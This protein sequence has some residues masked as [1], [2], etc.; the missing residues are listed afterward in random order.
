MCGI[1]G[2][3]AS[4]PGTTLPDLE[5]RLLA[6]NEIQAH[7]GPDDRGIFM[8]P[9]RR[10]GLANCRLAIRDLSPAGHMPMSNADASLWITY[11]GELYDVEELRT[12]LLRLGYTFR[13]GSDTEVILNGYEAWGG[14]VVERLRGIFAFAVLDTRGASPLLFLARDRLGVK[15]LY[16]LATPERFAFASELGT[17]RA[18][19][20]LTRGV[21]PAGL[22]AYLLLGSVPPPMTIFRDILALP[23][24]NTLTVRLPGDGSQP[25]PVSYWAPRAHAETDDP[26][27]A[28]QRI[29]A[30]LQN[31]VQ[32]ELV[33][34]V[35]LGAFLSGGL[36]SSA[37]VGLMRA[38]TDGTIRTCSMTF[39]EAEYNEAP[40]AAAMARA[41]GAEHYERKV[42]A[43]DVATQMEGFLRAMGQPTLD[44]LN[45][46]FVSQTAREAGLTVALSGLGGD[47]LFGGYGNTFRGGKQLLLGLAL[48]N[49]VPRGT[50]LARRA[51]EALPR[52]NR[53]AKLSDA[54][55]RPPSPASAYL[56]RR[57]NFA[58]S[59]VRTLVSEDVWAEAMETFD[60]IGHI[61][62]GAGRYFEGGHFAWTSRAELTGYT[63][64]QLL[65]DTDVMS[66]AHSLEVRVPFLDHTLV[67][68]VLKLPVTAHRGSGPKP[69]LVAAVRDL[70][71]PEVAAR[72]TKQ[73][74]TFPLQLWMQGALQDRMR[75]LL[76]NAVER[77]WLRPDAVQ[78]IW[79]GYAKGRLHWSRPW[80]LAMLGNEHITGTPFPVPQAVASGET[81]E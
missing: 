53:W 15:P 20:S 19:D 73:G 4:S 43:G 60:P 72:R 66:M 8:L 64:S 33:S 27:D 52:G 71:P 34:D 74:F 44:G 21:N 32:G 28:P 48:A 61:E 5:A 37:I 42:S 26:A 29:R 56:A 46:Y 3:F 65:R 12:D 69:L 40:Y 45:T 18:A 7:R 79:S 75:T 57:G 25:H 41:V 9:G 77:T 16:Y 14:S 36:D 70:L 24:G 10:G 47:E 76:D 11:N 22:V 31:A 6:M 13:S 68:T 2:L 59:E 51:I 54:L 23:A 38:S 80:A 81:V 63:H 67:E 17:L 58:P 30:A 78:P 55:A 50:H 35:P 1:A 62:A 49:A 39:E